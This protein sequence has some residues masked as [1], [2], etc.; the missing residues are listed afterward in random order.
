MIKA[1]II[2]GIS[3]ASLICGILLIKNGVIKDDF[4]NKMKYIHSEYL[5]ERSK[6]TSVVLGIVLII[7][8]I[9]I[10]KIKTK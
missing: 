3:G 8:G 9:M 6:K 4:K 2:Y 1:L 10:L 5:K 7:F